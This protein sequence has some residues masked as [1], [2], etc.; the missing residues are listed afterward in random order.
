MID[1]S[2]S[3]EG[4][5]NICGDN[6]FHLLFHGTYLHSC[7]IVV[8]HCLVPVAWMEPGCS[9]ISVTVCPGFQNFETC[10]RQSHIPTIT[11]GTTED[12]PRS[13]SNHR[14]NEFIILLV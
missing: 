8:E 9:F 14:R 13:E 1:E 2:I 5:L 7:K 12:P 3:K 11:M 10:Q 4:Y 6:C